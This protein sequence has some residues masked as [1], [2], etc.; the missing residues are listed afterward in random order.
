[1]SMVQKQGA[2]FVT[3]LVSFVCISRRMMLPL[4]WMTPL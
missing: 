4:K 1:M 3:P 2:V